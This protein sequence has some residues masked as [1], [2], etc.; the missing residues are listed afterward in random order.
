MNILFPS[1]LDANEE[2][3]AAFTQTSSFPHLPHVFFTSYTH[4]SH[5]ENMAVEAETKDMTRIDLK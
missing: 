4:K 3:G 1:S 5:K 2:A